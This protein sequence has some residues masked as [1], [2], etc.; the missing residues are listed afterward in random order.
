MGVSA[1][2]SYVTWYNEFSGGNWATW[3]PGEHVSPGDVGRFDENLRFNHCDTLTNY[4][5]KFSISRELPVTS[6]LYATGKSFR[7][8]SKAAGQS[9]AGF[10]SLGGLDAGIRLTAQRQHA[11]LLQLQKAGESR[12]AT[13]MQDLLAQIAALVRAG[14]WDLDLIVVSR[15]IRA[16]Q[17]F[18]AISRGAG[19]SVE[20]QAAG[21]AKLTEDLAIGGA[22]LKL[23]SD[24]EASGF[25]L[26]EFGERTTPVFYPPIR[27]RKSL[28]DQLLPWRTDG[29]W[30]IDPAGG[31]HEVDKLLEDLSGF[32]PEARRYDPHS[33]A[34]PLSDLEDISY[35]ELFEVVQSPPGTIRND[36]ISQSVVDPGPRHHVNL[37]PK[38]GIAPDQSGSDSIFTPRE[39]AVLRFMRDYVKKNH[40]TPTLREIGDAV[41]LRSMSS[42]A[43]SI[44]RLREGGYLQL[45][46]ASSQTLDELIL[47]VPDTE[48]ATSGGASAINFAEQPSAEPQEAV[49]VP[50]IGQIAA[51]RPIFAYEN[52]EDIFVLPRHLVGKGDLFL[53]RVVGDSMINAAIFDGDFVVVRQ[54]N[55][56]ENGQIVAAMFEDE[57]TVKTLKVYD[58]HRMLLPWNPMYV[59]IPADD[60]VILGIVKAVIRRV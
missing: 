6:R 40:R 52:I 48:K 22:E 9:S 53:L 28:W 23:S 55:T 54:Q 25:M 4:G 38:D 21:N 7:V 59:P 36:D 43:Y 39:F 41:R 8:E 31:R 30:I 29:P 19:Q 10:S 37:S 14:K 11:C 49:Y 20:L 2:K 45:V 5:I 1:C 58:E 60:A 26:Y 35:D 47:S 3:E 57:A 13:K 50:L 33:S 12:I 51:G 34:M 24:A 46:S 17:G 32:D 15:R 16:Q 44:S 18:A 42:I 56:A 27:V